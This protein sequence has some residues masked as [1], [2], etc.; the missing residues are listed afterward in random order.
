M[1]DYRRSFVPG[2][3]FFFTV[4]TYRRLPILTSPIA[5][6]QLRSAFKSVNEKWPFT[7]QAICLLPNHLHCI[8]SLPEEDANYPLRWR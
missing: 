5:R 8:W 4:V 3:T 6:D 2:G 1:P 7:N